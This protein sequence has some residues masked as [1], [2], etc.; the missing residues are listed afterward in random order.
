M[1]LTFT[2]MTKANAK[3]IFQWHY[4]PPY[5]TYNIEADD[6]ADAINFFVAPQNNY[7]A[8]THALGELTAFCCFGYDAQVPGGD[9]RDDA[10]DIGLGVR[11]N[12]TGRGNGLH[13]VNAVLDFARQRFSP[14]QFRVTIAA[15]NG[16][17]QRVWQKAGFEL[18][19]TFR[20]NRGGRTFVVMTRKGVS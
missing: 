4:E 3:A 20:A 14:T 2:P 10:L 8:I 16:R 1:S 19:Q 17:A 13:Y 7:Y 15:F 11:P 9:Y 6:V 18:T 5:D 12:L